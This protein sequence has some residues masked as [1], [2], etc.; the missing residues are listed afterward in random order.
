MANSVEVLKD[1]ICRAFDDGS[2]RIVPIIGSGLH[3]H[4]GA[5]GVPEFDLCGSNG[6]A[7]WADLLVSASLDK[8][9]RPEFLVP[10][11]EWDDDPT[12]VWESM[13]VAR[14][15][16]LKTGPTHRQERQLR[17]RVAR[18]V[19]GATPN[20]LEL[21]A[22]GGV[23]A[24][25]GFRDI[26]SL[27]FDRSLDRALVGAGVKPK[28]Y[29]RKPAQAVEATNNR[30]S[31]LPRLWHPHGA[32]AEPHEESA[33]GKPEFTTDE[34]QLGLRHYAISTSNV[35]KDVRAF[36]QRKGS[37]KKQGQV[38]QRF[39]EHVRE[40]PESWVDVLLNSDIV[41]IGCGLSRVELDLWLLLH[42]RQR[43]LAR[44]PEAERPQAFFLHP[45]EGFPRHICKRPAG[46][47]PVVT[48]SHDE[49]W[50]LLLGKWWV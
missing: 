7:N 6:L 31:G 25:R 37:W 35:L 8:K 3:R 24:R 1:H 14:A 15:G 11:L 5:H 22:F 38:T 20:P 44:V 49:C 42:E 9:G 45:L 50:E 29:G 33:S 47:V 26:V 2:R 10:R 12:A 41:F 39:H 17:A 32:V 48:R 36:R 43:E 16:G 28:V 21:E 40:Q 19:R 34:I 18:L 23:L 13:L 27:N 4:L 30:T 46:L